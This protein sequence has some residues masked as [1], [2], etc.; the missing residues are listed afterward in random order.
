MSI[1]RRQPKGGINTEA[2]GEEGS[3]LIAP[4]PEPG[5][6]KPSDFISGAIADEPSPQK[7][8][9]MAKLHFENERLRAQLLHVRMSCPDATKD[10]SPLVSG[11]PEAKHRPEGTDHQAVLKALDAEKLKTQQYAERIQELEAQPSWH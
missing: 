5:S 2:E 8:L 10:L 11:I 1:T 4:K 3:V 9:E 6:G 7:S